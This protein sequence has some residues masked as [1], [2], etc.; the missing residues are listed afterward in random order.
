MDSRFETSFALTK[1]NIES[2]KSPFLKCPLCG[3]EDAKYKRTE[4]SAGEDYVPCSRYNTN[5]S[6]EI[7]TTCIGC[8]RVTRDGM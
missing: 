2:Y 8:D 4:E 5:L 1:R 7:Y 6:A 3:W